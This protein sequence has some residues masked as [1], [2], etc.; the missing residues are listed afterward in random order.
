MT[1]R[2]TVDT[3]NNAAGAMAKK[4]DSQGARVEDIEL[5][6]AHIAKK[7]PKV[8]EIGCGNGRDAKE[9]LKLTS[10]Y[11]G[12]DISKAMI[13]IAK[14]HN[15]DGDFV[16][17]DAEKFDFP[18]SDMIIA[19]AS[20]LH[21]DKEAVKRILDKAYEC[22]SDDGVFFISLKHGEY[23]EEEKTDEFGTR[24]FYYYSPEAIKALAPRFKPVYEETQELRGQ[25]WFTLIL[26]K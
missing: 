9:I 1:T 3:Y 10:S 7:N 19:F 13:E 26:Q 16:V 5:A 12:I 25:K 24:T 14:K 22:L 6:F 21:S 23:H 4:F 15:L 18:K 17:A 11:F 20:L 8:F 2:Q